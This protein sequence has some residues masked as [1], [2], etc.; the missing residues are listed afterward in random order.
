MEEKIEGLGDLEILEEGLELI[1]I[2][3]DTEK[4]ISTS[5]LGCST[6]FSSSLFSN[7]LGGTTCLSI[8][9]LSSFISSY[10]RDFGINVLFLVFV[11]KRVVT[12]FFE[13]TL[14]CRV[15]IF[16]SLK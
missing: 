14:T 15:T 12:P 8:Q 3:L 6:I 4:L 16:I 10:F 13:E 5:L 7:G 9:F 2:L 1:T 11:R